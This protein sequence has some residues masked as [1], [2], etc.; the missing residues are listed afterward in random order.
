MLWY[1][2]CNCRKAILQEKN[3][4][5]VWFP[6]VQTTW[7]HICY[8]I[9]WVLKGT[10]Q[11]RCSSPSP[12][13]ITSQEKSLL[14]IWSVRKEEKPAGKRTLLSLGNMPEF[15]PTENLHL[16]FNQPFLQQVRKE[17][18][19]GDWILLPALDRR[20]GQPS[21]RI[22]ACTLGMKAKYMI[23]TFLFSMERPRN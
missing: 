20:A 5:W 16:I 6:R 22:C 1:H 3:I 19:R 9:Y 10:W 18:F 21:N 15:N 11:D 12:S 23:N 14:L 2:F 7:R 4:K 13:E 17:D 8:L